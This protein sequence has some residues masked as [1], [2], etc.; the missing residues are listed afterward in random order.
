MDPKDVAL[1]RYKAIEPFLQRRATLEDIS[2]QENTPVR[3]LYN[4]ASA[5]KRKGL[6]GL[7]PKVRNDKGGHRSTH[8]EVVNVVQGLYL[9]TP[10]V[11][12][13]T[14]YRTV[15]EICKRNGWDVPSYGVVRNIVQD[16]PASLKTL[17]HEGSKA[18]KQ[19]FGLLHRFE[20]DRP[21]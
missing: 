19:A 8:D 3:T 5:F 4:W 15:Q 9:R 21:N 18:Y 20:A 16:I 7:K 12:V 11:P 14:V 1:Q 2:K 13:T 6:D 17:A 10:P